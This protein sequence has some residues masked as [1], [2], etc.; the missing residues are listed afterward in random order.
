MSIWKHSLHI[1]KT[2]FNVNSTNI[3]DRDHTCMQP[4]WALSVSLYTDST[5]GNLSQGVRTP[6]RMSPEKCNDWWLGMLLKPWGRAGDQGGGWWWWHQALCRQQQWWGLLEE[7]GPLYSPSDS[8]AAI[9]KTGMDF[10]VYPT[11][12]A[13]QMAV[14]LVL[15]SFPHTHQ[16]LHSMIWIM[17]LYWPTSAVAFNTWRN[18]QMPQPQW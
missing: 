11:Q 14:V 6:A 1:Q 17:G 13:S 12:H 10:P 15:F 7:D 5:Y 4:C 2:F 3:M 18:P 8:Q 9:F 16:K